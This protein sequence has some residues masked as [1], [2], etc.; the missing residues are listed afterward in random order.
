LF[1]KKYVLFVLPIKHLYSSSV[2][3][4]ETLVVYSKKPGIIPGFL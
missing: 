3:I 4:P 2:S 1:L